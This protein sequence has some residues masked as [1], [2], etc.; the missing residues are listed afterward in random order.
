MTWVLTEFAAN[1][2]AIRMGLAIAFSGPCC[3]RLIHRPTRKCV[4]FV[5]G[6]IRG[7]F[8]VPSGSSVQWN[9]SSECAFSQDACNWHD[10]R[11]VMPVRIE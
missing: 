8:P 10:P 2:P 6:H 11:C 1:E 3:T 7:H 4:R 9:L 5:R